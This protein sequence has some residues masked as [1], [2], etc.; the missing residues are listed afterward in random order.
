MLSPCSR[1]EHSDT[2]MLAYFAGTDFR[3]YPKLLGCVPGFWGW[4]GSTVRGRIGSR[5]LWRWW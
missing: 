3:D 4:T 5:S 1:Q 2:D